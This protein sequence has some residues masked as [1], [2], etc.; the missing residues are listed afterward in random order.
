MNER[1]LIQAENRI[2]AGIKSIQNGEKS[3]KEANLGGLMNAI[4]SYDEVL[5]EK[6]LVLYVK[7][8]K[9]SFLKK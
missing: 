6:L 5:F 7:A 9:S 1:I 2:R 3:L 8:T 4:K